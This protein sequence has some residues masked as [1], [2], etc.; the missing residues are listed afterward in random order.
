MVNV[1][2]HGQ[3]V[4][5]MTEEQ[6][7]KQCEQTGEYINALIDAMKDI[8]PPNKFVELINE[9]NSLFKEIERLKNEA[10]G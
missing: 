8:C 6:F 1:T 10:K 9:R 7:V 4:S 5:T 2:Y 3:M